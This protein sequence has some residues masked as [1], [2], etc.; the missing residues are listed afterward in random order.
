MKMQAFVAGAKAEALG[1]SVFVHIRNNDITG[2]LQLFLGPHYPE[3]KM[4]LQFAV[5]GPHG[6]TCAFAP[7]GR[8]FVVTRLLQNLGLSEGLPI[9]PDVHHDYGNS[10]AG[11]QLRIPDLKAGLAVP[12]LVH[13]AN[14]A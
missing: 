6:I 4:M 7:T 3:A 9:G 1:F 5:Y 11:F 14:L 10:G 8:T 12:I 13:D 2:R